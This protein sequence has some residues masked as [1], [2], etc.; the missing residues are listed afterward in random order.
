VGGVEQTG[1]VG[2]WAPATCNIDHCAH[3]EAN[4]VVQE[5]IG[6]D[7]KNKT[8]VLPA[9]LPFRDG[10]PTTVMRFALT[11]GTERVEIVFAD[12]LGRG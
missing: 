12:Q 4:H 3:Q 2:N 6:L 7:M 1:Q 11:Y 9:R 5:S 8:F 10:D